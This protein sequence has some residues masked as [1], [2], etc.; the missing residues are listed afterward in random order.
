RC[1]VPLGQVGSSASEVGDV[2][3][4]GYRGSPHLSPGRADNKPGCCHDRDDRA[5]CA[6]EPSSS[7][8]MPTSKACAASRPRE[9][10]ENSEACP[11]RC[12]VQEPGLLEYAADNTTGAACAWLVVSLREYPFRGGGDATTR[13]SSQLRP[14]LLLHLLGGFVLGL[15]ERLELVRH[16]RVGLHQRIAVLVEVELLDERAACLPVGLGH[17]LVLLSL[18]PGRLGFPLVLSCKLLVLGGRLGGGDHLGHAHLVL[19]ERA[20]GGQAEGREQGDE[21]CTENQAGL[22]HGSPPSS[23]RETRAQLKT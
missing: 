6:N 3:R 7:H 21:C 9:V 14:P 5:A 23:R 8:V 2:P 1:P 20:E 19:C 18:C 12:L 4:T 11:G 17:Q 16:A 22:P 10:K 15:G 13:P